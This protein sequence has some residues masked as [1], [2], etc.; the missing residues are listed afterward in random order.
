ML[1]R[2]V[3]LMELSH[4][5]D[6]SA[7]NARREKHACAETDWVMGYHIYIRPNNSDSERKHDDYLNAICDRDIST[8]FVAYG[9]SYV[10]HSFIIQ[11]VSSHSS[12]NVKVILRHFIT[13]FISLLGARLRLFISIRLPILIG[14]G[15]TF[16]FTY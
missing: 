2:D 4:G 7:M 1:N 15:F 12:M 6:P 9:N 16:N 11:L 8:D 13:W 10:F 14:F 5:V 3:T